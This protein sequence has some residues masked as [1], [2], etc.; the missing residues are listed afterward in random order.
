MLPDRSRWLLERVLDNEWLRAELMKVK[1]NGKIIWK[2]D[3][4]NLYISRVERFLERLLLL[5]HITS[6]QPARATELLGLRYCNTVEGHHRNIFIDDG[7]VSTVTSYHKGYSVSGSTKIIHRYLSKEVDEVMIYYLWLMVP[8]VMN[9][10][11]L[12]YGEKTQPTYL[13]TLLKLQ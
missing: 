5:V 9:I 7:L 2:L 6:G 11:V 4:T 13:T 12:V 3:A 8:F 10:R 1:A